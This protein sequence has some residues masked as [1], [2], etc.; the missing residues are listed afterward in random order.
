MP[1]VKLSSMPDVVN[2]KH[3]VERRYGALPC[4]Q[5][6]GLEVL[7]HGLGRVRINVLQDACAPQ[8]ADIPS[9]VNGVPIVIHQIG[10][11]RFV[12]K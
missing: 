6:V 9:S 5:S 4:V 10:H 7:G 2:A 8:W 12:R 11:A 3:E 1:F